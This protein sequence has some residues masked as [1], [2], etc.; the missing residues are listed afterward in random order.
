[1]ITPVLGFVG[2]AVAAF[3]EGAIGFGF[4]TVATPPVA[5]PPCRC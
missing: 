3:I 2:L 5:N 4:P 1:M